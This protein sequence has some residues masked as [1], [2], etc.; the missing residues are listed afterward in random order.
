[1]DRLDMLA[2][3]SYDNRG[4]LQYLDFMERCISVFCYILT[5]LL[6][7]LERT[8]LVFFPLQ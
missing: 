5:E 3:A 8:D 6:Y 4:C 1:L 7:L 2:P